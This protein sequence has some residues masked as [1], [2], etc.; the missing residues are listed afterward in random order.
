MRLG[1]RMCRWQQGCVVG[2]IQSLLVRARRFSFHEDGKANDIQS[3]ASDST[4]RELMRDITRLMPDPQ[5]EDELLA[6]GKAF[7]N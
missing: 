6:P 4:D 5:S 1:E 7:L 3:Q 2:S